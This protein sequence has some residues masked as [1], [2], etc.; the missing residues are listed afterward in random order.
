MDAPTTENIR[1]SAHAGETNSILL[2]NWLAVIALFAAFC[3]TVPLAPSADTWWHLAT[4][5]YIAQTGTIPHVDPFSAT[6]AGKP[7]TAHEWLSDV[8]FYAA[9][10]ATGSMGL[11]FLACA[12]TTVAF[13][14]AYRSLGGAPLSRALALV[15]GVWAARPDFS[16]RPQLFSFLMAGIFL[17]LLR[18]Y[19]IGGPWKILFAIPILMLLWVNLHGGYALGLALIFLFIVGIALDVIWGREDRA[20]AMRTMKGL[21]LT[22]LGC[23]VVVPLNPNG[24]ALYTYPFE[25]L[26]SAAMQASIMEWHSPDFHSPMFY[27]L[28]ALLFLT[29]AVLALSPSRPKPGE[30]LL[31]V[32][33]GLAA[34]RSMRNLPFFALIAFPLL[35]RYLVFPALPRPLIPERLHRILKL[36]AIVLAAAVSAEF[37]SSRFAQTLQMEKARFPLRASA[38]LD[39][40]NL[41]APFLN[42][43]DFGGYLIWKLY[44]HYRVYIDGRADLYGDQFLNNFIQ[45]YDVNEDPRPA[46]D[47]AGIRTIIVEP[48]STLAGYLRIQ[49]DWNRAYEDPVAVIFTR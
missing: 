47:R 7:W 12:L 44:P 13:W 38:F 36:A 32:F 41:P 48:G 43:Y 39:Q 19:T 31:F 27:P 10:S 49:K 29:I 3:L 9:Y 35:G 23:L 46:L 11:L 5:R 42:S 22:L 6:A 33:F 21:L 24:F 2:Q 17:F 1:T 45:L 14:F 25:T 30:I 16:V 28:A 15:I 20:A 26:H 34:L 37:V 40:Q 8:I 18:R 4:G